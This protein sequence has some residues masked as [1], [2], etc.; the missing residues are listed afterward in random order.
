VAWAFSSTASALGSS[1][2]VDRTSIALTTDPLPE[3]VL[4][5]LVRLD[6]PWLSAWKI[7][8]CKVMAPFSQ[9]RS[10]LEMAHAY[11]T[12]RDRAK[13]RFEARM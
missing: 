3:K 6:V 2:R 10:C 11:P 8:G 12:Y 1:G 7:H 13:G 5:A 4:G 9:S